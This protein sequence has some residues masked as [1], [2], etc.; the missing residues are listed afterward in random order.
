MVAIPSLAGFMTARTSVVAPYRSSRSTTQPRAATA[1]AGRTA[2]PPS[3]ETS[4]P[5]NRCTTEAA[6]GRPS[7]VLTSTPKAPTPSSRPAS[8]STTWRWPALSTRRQGSRPVTSSPVRTTTSAST[9]STPVLTTTTEAPVPELPVD[10]APVPTPGMNARV[11]S[12]GTPGARS[13]PRVARG[14]DPSDAWSRATTTRPT[15]T[16]M[17]AETTDESAIRSVT[18]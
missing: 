6:I 15:R 8:R 4:S 3:A 10:T 1:A 5:P 9:V 16:S 7:N 12:S 18:S 17:V 13:S 14:P 11:A 2:R